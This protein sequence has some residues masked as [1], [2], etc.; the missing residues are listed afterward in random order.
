M[1]CFHG[2]PTSLSLKIKKNKINKIIKK[3]EAIS[4]YL[5]I[6]QFLSHL[7]AMI[8][9]LLPAG[10]EILTIINRLSQCCSLFQIASLSMLCQGLDKELWHKMPL[11]KAQLIQRA[12]KGA[13]RPL[14]NH[15][16]SL[17]L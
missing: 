7:L 16:F 8:P 1:R 3:N 17:C 15:R 5:H 10:R 9:T 11:T 13:M 2:L 6:V 4:T 12:N 14:P